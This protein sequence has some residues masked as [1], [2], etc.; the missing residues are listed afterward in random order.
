MGSVHA[1]ALGGRLASVCSNDPRQLAGDLSAV[2]G[3]LGD[4]VGHLD[5]SGVKKYSEIAPA[6]ADPEI[7]AVDLCLPTHMHETVAIKALRAGKHVLVEKPIAL[8][9][10]GA[11]RMIAEAEAQGRVLMTA[12]VLR[13][14]PEY[15]ALR[16]ALKPLGPVRRACFQR[17]CAEPAWGGWLKDPALSGGGPFD[18]L[19]HDVDMCLHLFGAPAAVAVTGLG[20]SIH[21]QLFYPDGVVAVITGGWEAPGAYPFRMEYSVTAERGAVEYRS[22]GLPPTLYNADAHTL[23]LAT[24]DG[25]KAEIDY[26]IACCESG[27]QPERCPPRESAQA[28]EL[29]RLLLKARFQNGEKMPCNL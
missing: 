19:I 10:A 17:R 23:P 6:L 25:Y 21:A 5:F 7:E 15:I 22:T 12:Q 18:L 1:R 4:P 2:Q 14:M 24:Q 28:V 26:F 13:F 11:H 20:N 8:D 27:T 9:G 29:M 16:D 3:N